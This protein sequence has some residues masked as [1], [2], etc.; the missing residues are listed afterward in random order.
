[1]Y[2]VVGECGGTKS[3]RKVAIYVAWKMNDI[4]PPKNHKVEPGHKVGKADIN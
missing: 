1:M 3:V 4:K 2:A